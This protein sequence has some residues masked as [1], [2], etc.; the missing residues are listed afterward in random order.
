MKNDN[1]GFSDSIELLKNNMMQ[2]KTLRNI[3]IL[4]GLAYLSYLL[5]DVL[6]PF[7]IALFIAYLINPYIN[8]I[9]NKLKVKKS[10]AIALGLISS[11]SFLALLVIVSIPTIGNEVEKASVILED[12]AH[13]IP[14]IPENIQKEIEQLIDSE[15]AKEF[16]DSNTINEA[17]DRLNPIINSVFTESLGFL[18]GLFNGFLILLYLIFILQGYDSLMKNWKNWIPKKYRIRSIEIARDLNSGMKS[19]F[20]GQATIALIVGILFCIG[21][22]IINLPLAIMLG[23]F[24]GLLNLVPYLQILGFIPAF[25][26]GTLH[27]I[28]TGQEL[29]HSYALIALIFAIVQIIQEAILIPRI[30]N[31]VTGLH[32]AIILLSLSIWGSLLGFA[33]LIIALPI[34]TLILSYYKRHINKAI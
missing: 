6:T 14:P 13:A 33:G 26:L 15:Y 16:I 4:S 2:E 8:L 27:S 9:H 5:I 21:F 30:M 18:K 32:P 28:E 10:I 12:Y 3:L 7:F 20:R 34:S 22:K 11:L 17:V 1:F 25:I 31:K 23:I 24:I 29:W 19:Y